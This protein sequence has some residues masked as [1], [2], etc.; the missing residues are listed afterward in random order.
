[1]ASERKERRDIAQEVTDRIIERI[2]E[3]GGDL[4]WRKPWR[5]RA[6]AHPCRHE[7]IGYRGINHLILSLEAF[8]RSFASPYWMTFRQSKEYGGSVI[9]GEKGTRVVFYGVADK[10]DGGGESGGS[11]SAGDRRG[12]EGAG[13]ADATYRFLKSFVVFNAS[14]IENLPERFHPVEDDLD[15]GSRPIPELEA[16]FAKLPVPVVKG[17]EGACY[18][19]ITDDILMPDIARFEEPAR[20]YSTLAHEHV[21]SCGIKSRLGRDCFAR[22][23]ADIKA[24][25][26]EEL[27]A[28]LGSA[29]IC[30]ELGLMPDHLDDHAAYLNSW[31][32]ALKSDKRYIFRAAADAQRAADWVFRAAGHETGQVEPARAG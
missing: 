14:Q 17:G 7:G 8:A 26:E 19:E 12:K 2:E 30:A 29:F 9:K 32:K 3:S 20:F 21:H 22:Y 31:L 13:D 23:H 16:F 27:V 10:R 15:T 28:E 11:G 25:A 1:M 24:R 5:S 4:P 18:R 6:I